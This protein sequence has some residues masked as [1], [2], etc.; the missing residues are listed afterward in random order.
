MSSP[1]G[2]GH[3]GDRERGAC[4][5]P[6][7]LLGLLALGLAMIPLG[8][9]LLSLGP[10]GVGVLTLVVAAPWTLLAAARLARDTS[11]E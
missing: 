5:S 6:P 9:L 4:P 11:G 2:G 7:V 1:E 10:I 3:G 8:M